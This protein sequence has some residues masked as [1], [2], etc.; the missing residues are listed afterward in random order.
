[1]S[2]TISVINRSGGGF[3]FTHI[4]LIVCVLACVPVIAHIK[5]RRPGFH[6]YLKISE[7]KSIKDD[8]KGVV[9]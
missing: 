2:Q 5:W 3:F 8:G 1:M 6:F 4:K 9:F 7:V